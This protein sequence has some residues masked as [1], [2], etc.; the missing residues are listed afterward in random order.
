MICA[1]VLQARLDSVRLPRKAL[2]PLG[3][4]EL[5]VIF[6]VMEALNRV[7]CDLRVL[8]CPEDCLAPFGPWAEKAGF[9]LFPGSRDDVLNRYC[10]AI[11]R[12]S[13]DRVI[14]ATGDNPF[15]FADAAEAVN[16]EGLEQGAAYAGYT[17]LPYGAGVESVDAEALLRAEREAKQQPEREH[18]CPYLYGHPELFKL[19]RPPA[20]PRWRESFLRITVD[21][22]ED[23]D[24]ARLIYRSLPPGEERYRGEGI[25]ETCRQLRSSPAGIL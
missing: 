14:R 4:E 24:R 23:Y 10:G 13:I 1:V 20:P 17:G 8:A 25:I 9:V 18:V 19:H 12:F 16:R 15:V 2:L 22:P 5:P 3:E 21:T 7:P 6:R 11:R